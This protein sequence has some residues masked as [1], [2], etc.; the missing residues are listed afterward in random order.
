M[1]LY[2]CGRVSAILEGG[3]AACLGNRR[4]SCTTFHIQSTGNLHMALSTQGCRLAEMGIYR[5]CE[6]RCGKA[7][8]PKLLSVT[9]VSAAAVD[10][11]SPPA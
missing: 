9:Q 3:A 1:S 5:W 6:V 11:H 8:Q 7:P 4:S 2:R 10:V